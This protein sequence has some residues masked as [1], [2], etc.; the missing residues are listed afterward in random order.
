MKEIDLLL[1]IVTTKDKSEI[2][3]GI[4]E[5]EQYHKSIIDM[6]A[7]IES[8]PDPS[9]IVYLDSRRR[10]A[11]D[12]AM[13]ALNSINRIGLEYTNKYVLNTE[14]MERYEI[15]EAILGYLQY[16]IDRRRK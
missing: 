2:L 9:M 15:G 3:N 10:S 1:K 6:E 13:K 4:N 8:R 16:K 5:F 14:G 12:Q 11:H 7:L